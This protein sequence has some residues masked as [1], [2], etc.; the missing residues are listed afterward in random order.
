MSLSGKS[1]ARL[2]FTLSSSYRV[3]VD[4]LTPYAL[5]GGVVAKVV[6]ILQSLKSI[7][8]IIF[9]CLPHPTCKTLFIG[10]ALIFRGIG[11][12]SRFH[13]CI[14]PIL[15]TQPVIARFFSC[16][17]KFCC[18]FYLQNSSVKVITPYRKPG[19]LP[20]NGHSSQIFVVIKRIIPPSVNF[21][22]RVPFH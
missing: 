21:L 22:A 2:L 8:R 9:N 10:N 6:V 3:K 1:W 12:S 7:A 19:R 11:D 14:I 4:S 18:C 16:H 5:I 15:H 17:N 20:L 13:V